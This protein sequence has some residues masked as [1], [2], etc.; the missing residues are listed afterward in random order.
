MWKDGRLYNCA[1]SVIFAF[2]EECNISEE[3]AERIGTNLGWGMHMGSTC[4]AINGALIALGGMGYGKD[5]TLRLLHTV[6]EKHECTDCAALIR[7]AHMQGITRQRHCAKM[8]FECISLVEDITNQK[9]LGQG[10]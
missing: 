9:D 5:E 8:I 4:G 10:V 1:Q 6:R 2:S 3:L 7:Q